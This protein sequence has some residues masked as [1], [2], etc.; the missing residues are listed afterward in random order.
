[1]CLGALLADVPHSRPLPVGVFSP[2]PHLAHT[3][4]LTPNTYEGPTGIVG[5]LADAA[6][7]ADIPTLS[8]YVSVPHYAGGTPRTRP[9]HH[10]TPRGQR[11]RDRP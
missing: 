4:D 2:D 6:A 10:L 3:L 9:G 1:M 5:V 11:R 8:C 7:Q